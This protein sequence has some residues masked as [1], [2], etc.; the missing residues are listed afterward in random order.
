[1]AEDTVRDRTTLAALFADNT[2]GDIGAQ[3][4]RDFL[5]SLDLAAEGAQKL[6]INGS[7]VALP[8]ADG[9][10]GDCLVTNAN[11]TTSW[12]ARGTGN[13]DVSGPASAGADGN[14]ALYNGTGGKTLKDGPA[15]GT[16]ANCLVQLNGSAQLPALD[17]SLLTGV[18][19]YSSVYSTTSD[20]ETPTNGMFWFRSDLDEFRVR[21]DDTTWRLTVSPV[22]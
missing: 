18:G 10:S 3:D 11:G 14:V 7:P 13:G 15:I 4:L 17:G 21:A 9:S 12:A 5:I 22:V 6:Q 16:A 19:A 2:S 20:P 1:M 8:A